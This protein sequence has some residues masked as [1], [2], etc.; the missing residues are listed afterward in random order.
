MFPRKMFTCRIQCVRYRIC[1]RRK[2]FPELCNTTNCLMCRS[3]NI[4]C[5]V[6][7]NASARMQ[8]TGKL[9]RS[10]RSHQTFARAYFPTWTKSGM[11]AYSAY[12]NDEIQRQPWCRSLRSVNRNTYAV[13]ARLCNVVQ[14]KWAN[15]NAKNFEDIS[16][17]CKVAAAFCTL[18]THSML[19][20]PTIGKRRQ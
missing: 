6:C 10:P 3:L 9:R 8:Q 15:S 11:H 17:L 19:A 16:Y 5:R 1:F 20:R 18:K 13:E 2:F 7:A 12:A 4:R 14:G